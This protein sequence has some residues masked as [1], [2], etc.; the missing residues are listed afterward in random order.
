MRAAER[1]LRSLRLIEGRERLVMVRSWWP[2]LSL[3]PRWRGIEWP[4]MLIDR[5][6]SRSSTVP[7]WN[8]NRIAYLWREGLEGSAPRSAQTT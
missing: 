6:G 1:L 7:L 2:T 3:D 8:W 4:C 5:G